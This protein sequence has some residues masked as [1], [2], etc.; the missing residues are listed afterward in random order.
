[1]VY[2]CTNEKDTTY[3]NYGGRG[4]KVCD[5]WLEKDKGVFN[6]VED[7]GDRPSP[8][9]SIDRIDNDG[10]YTT[11]NCRWATRH[12][13]M[14]NR[15]NSNRTV[16]VSHI[17]K[18]NKWQGSMIVRGVNYCKRFG[19]EEEAISYRRELEKLHG[20]DLFKGDNE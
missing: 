1:M 15:R 3:E 4:I 12:Q 7:M 9:H 17:P 20:V 14:A 5:R 16:G 18:E 13:Q 10:D 6:F 19:T 8:E 11:E 2:R